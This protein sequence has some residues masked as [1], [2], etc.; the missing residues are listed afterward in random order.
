MSVNRRGQY[1]LS[2]MSRRKHVQFNERNKNYASDP[3]LHKSFDKVSIITPQNV[4]NSSHNFS[5]LTQNCNKE[6][7]FN[8]NVSVLAQNSI[9]SNPEVLDAAQTLINVPNLQQKIPDLAQFSQSGNTKCHCQRVA[10]KVTC[11][12]ESDRCQCQIKA[13]IKNMPRINVEDSDE[14]GS[15]IPHRYVRLSLCRYV[16]N[17]YRVIKNKLVLCQSGL[18]RRGTKIDKLFEGGRNLKF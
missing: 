10:E 15:R 9:I 3:N 4:P 5:G 11:S 1:Q 12:C 14:A 6:S 2:L 13:Q 18:T 7:N 17:L 8:K 16:L